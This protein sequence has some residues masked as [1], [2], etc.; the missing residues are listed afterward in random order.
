[1]ISEGTLL[2]RDAVA[3]D[4]D[5]AVVDASASD[6]LEWTV[7]ASS[8]SLPEDAP[9]SS[10]MTE[11]DLTSSVE[12]ASSAFDALETTP[13]PPT[14]MPHPPTTTTITTTADDPRRRR[15][16]EEVGRVGNSFSAERLENSYS[17]NP[18]C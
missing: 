8:V 13:H 2:L 11:V 9:P 15:N 12:S 7:D 18:I 6:P 17:F 3:K 14:K 10:S 4:D 16:E 1:M 5:A